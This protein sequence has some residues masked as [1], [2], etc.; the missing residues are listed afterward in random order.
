MTVHEVPIAIAVSAPANVRVFDEVDRRVPP[1]RPRS[2]WWA[3]LLHATA[4]PSGIPPGRSRPELD[5]H[6]AS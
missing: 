6:S 4:L 2:G 1:R 5:G 3:S